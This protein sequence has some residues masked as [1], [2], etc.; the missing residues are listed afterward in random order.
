M[1]GKGV[2]H[3]PT[4]K[5][6]VTLAVDGKHTVSVQC[7]DPVAVTEALVWAKETYGQLGHPPQTGPQARVG[8]D[9]RASDDT[10]T[11][12]AESDATPI[13]AVHT[14]P[15]VRVSGR[16]GDFWSCHEKNADDSWC[17]YRP[18]QAS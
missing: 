2:R 13:C 1:M 8:T 18:P 14:L 17:S 15:M 12:L 7:D 6:Q 9:D 16:R 10:A 5:Y 3:M 4:T 11:D